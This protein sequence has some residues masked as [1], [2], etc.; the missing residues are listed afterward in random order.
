MSANERRSF[1]Q[2][3]NEYSAAAHSRQFKVLA[4]AAVSLI[5]KQEKRM[6]AHLLLHVKNAGQST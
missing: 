5:G 1:F 4:A 3:G 2:S 6:P